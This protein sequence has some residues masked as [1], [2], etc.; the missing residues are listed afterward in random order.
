ML[1]VIRALEDWQKLNDPKPEKK[2]KVKEEAPKKEK[3][4]HKVNKSFHHPR[5]YMLQANKE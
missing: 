2:V 1:A 3:I 4:P 5:A